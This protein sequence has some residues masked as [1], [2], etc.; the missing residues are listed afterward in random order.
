MTVLP[1]SAD[2]FASFRDLIEE[3]CGLHFDESQRASLSAS[4]R[5]RMQQLGIV[6]IGEYYE[7]LRNRASAATDD[8]FRQLIN[9]V[10]VTET[11]FFRNPSH[12]RL[13]RQHIL[14]ALLAGPPRTLRIWSAGCS[15][16]E[17][18]Y[19]I[20]L[21]LWDMGVYSACPDWTFEI[22]GTD[23]NTDVLEAA[24]RGIYAAHAL[25]NVGDDVL[26]LHFRRDG[27]LFHLNDDIKR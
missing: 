18:A 3:R 2:D 24:R 23:L 22:V 4:L 16:G 12:F 14:P 10:T 26:L 21:T 20:A 19:S 9:L 8:E 6:E 1:V 5:A 11:C 25:R 7:R 27:D 15:S 17:E 13:L